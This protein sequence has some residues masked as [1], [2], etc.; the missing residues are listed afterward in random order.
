M[1]NITDRMENIAENSFATLSREEIV[2]LFEKMLNNEPVESLRRTVEAMKIA[3]YRSQ[4]VEAVVEDAEVAEGAEGAEATDDSVAEGEES[5]AETTVEAKGELESRFKTLVAQ[6]RSLRDAHLAEQEQQRELNLRIKLQIIEELKELVESDETQTHTFNKFRELQERWRAAGQVPVANIKDIWEQ[7]N[8]QIER[9]YGVIK[10]NRE[11]RD[12]DQRKN[13]ELKVAL[14]ERAEALLQVAN[15]IDAFREL[16]LLHDEWREVGPVDIESKES[17]WLRFK[18]ATST[19]NKRHANHFDA[20][21][22][23]QESNLKRKE[24][25]CEKIEAFVANQP[26]THNGW[27]KCS[28]ELQQIQQEWRTVGFAPKKDNTTIYSRFRAA[29]DAFFAAKRLFYAASKDEQSQN[30]AAKIAL[31]EA[32]ETISKSEDWKSASDELIKLQAE[33]KGV[34]A[35]SR[36]D[37]DKVWKRFRAA[38]DLFFERKATHFS[39]ESNDQQSNLAAK[40]EILT[41]MKS[42]V[43]SGKIDSIDVIKNFQRRWSEIGFVP[44]KSKD[45]LQTKYKEVV[46]EMFKLLRSEESSRNIGAYRNR[47]ES[48]KGKGGVVGEREKL[49]LRL[50]QVKQDIIQLENN[51]GF[52]AKSKGAEGMIADVQRKIEA[53]MREIEQIKEKI[54]MI[55]IAERG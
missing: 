45:A 35:V 30:L 50:K 11:L 16:Q 24:E 22:G 51:M 8:Y 44:I 27:N 39:S 3:F 20:L 32:A 17:I 55:D 48:L 7:Y 41:K 40:E 2:A 9:F 53:G 1:E 13:L 21:R 10:I 47:I 43:E 42:V 19:I 18:E 29:C 23:E 26:T 6:Y 14:C 31:C 5:V 38:C 4:D 34:G 36:R 54:K 37:S 49:S 46:D 33:W 28:E 15:V 25:M 52:F 12:L